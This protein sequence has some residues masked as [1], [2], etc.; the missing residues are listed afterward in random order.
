MITNPPTLVALDEVLKPAAMARKKAFIVT[1]NV[2]TN[3]RKTKNWLAVLCRPTRKY[4]M[5]PKTT[6]QRKAMGMST[7][8]KARASMKG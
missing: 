4:K 1:D 6:E 7:R 3:S 2:K 5:T 8:V